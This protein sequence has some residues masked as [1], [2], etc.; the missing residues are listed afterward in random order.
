MMMKI[1]AI[2]AIASLCNELAFS[3]TS[4]PAI[5]RRLD[6]KISSS[7]IGMEGP[8]IPQQ[9]PIARK[10]LIK[11]AREIDPQLKE[12]KTGSYSNVG[13]SNRL[14][15]VLTPVVEGGGSCVYVACR[16]FLWNRIDVGCKMTVIELSTKTK[17]SSKPDLFVHSPVQL[18][19]LN[20]FRKLLNY[21]AVSISVSFR[22]KLKFCDNPIR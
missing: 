7:L 19:K 21:I 12:K 14:G 13:W 11:K 9:Y 16:P 10:N 5:F 22:T 18:G 8:G 6:K 1:R 4:P 3:F 15:T 20:E 2:L 17:N